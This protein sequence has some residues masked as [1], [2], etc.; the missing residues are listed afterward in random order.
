[1]TLRKGRDVGEKSAGHHQAT[2]TQGI[3]VSGV[4]IL[5]R[6]RSA[7]LRLPDI[8]RCG[9]SAT[10]A[11]AL[12]DP[13]RREILRVLHLG[14]QDGYAVA[15]LLV[16]DRVVGTELDIRIQA[17]AL[18]D[19]ALV[20]VFSD[21]SAT[22]RYRSLAADDRQILAILDVLEPADSRW[23]DSSPM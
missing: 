23:R 16:H 2:G 1:M 4:P 20:E 13:R 19:S 22:A 12:D 9:L 3:Q 8:M 6:S 14:V 17:M 10:Y 18:V 15:D 5:P 11:R 7:Q 21:E